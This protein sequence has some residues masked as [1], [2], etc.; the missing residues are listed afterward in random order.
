MLATMCGRFA[1][2]TEPV[3]VARFLQVTPDGVEGTGSQA[4]TSRR[5]SAPWCS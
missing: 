4:G 1:L 5:P 2:Y 3:N